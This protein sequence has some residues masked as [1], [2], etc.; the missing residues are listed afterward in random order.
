MLERLDDDDDDDS[1]KGRCWCILMMV[2]MVL[3]WVGER[4][5]CLVGSVWLVGWLNYRECICVSVCMCCS[6]C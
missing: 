4:V 5:G 6:C 2:V 1:G 3:V